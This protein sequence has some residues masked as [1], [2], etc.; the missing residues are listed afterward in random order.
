VNSFNFH[1]SFKIA[2]FSLILYFF[3]TQRMWPRSVSSPAFLPLLPSL[4]HYTN[5]HQPSTLGHPYFH[6][7]FQLSLAGVVF[8]TGPQASG[9]M[10]ACHH[11]GAGAVCI[12]RVKARKATL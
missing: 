6:V 3:L 12:W 5:S 10:V 1:S 7:L 4:V 9:D 8:P 2:V 11:A